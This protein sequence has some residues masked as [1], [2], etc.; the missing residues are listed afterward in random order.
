[1]TDPD[2]HPIFVVGTGRS[3][4]T[5]VRM[6]LNAHP[7]IHLTHEASFYLLGGLSR[8]ATPREWLDRYLATVAF[9]WLG[10]DPERVR[11]AAG[12]RPPSVAVTVRAIMKMQAERHGKV[13]YG[14]KTPL[15]ATKLPQIFED[16]P[17]ARVVNVVR[18]PRGG[19]AS[20]L[21]MP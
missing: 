7:R 14:D 13:R 1:M 17:G 16:F 18:D 6:M 12:D 4:T 21:R 8:K 19:V 20:L 11:E 5:L 10:L 9:A 2:R 3:G 15:H